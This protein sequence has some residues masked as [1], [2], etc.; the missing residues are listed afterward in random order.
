MKCL[1]FKIWLFFG[2][3]F[4]AGI[5]LFLCPYSSEFSRHYIKDDCY[6]H[7]AWIFDR[8]THNAT[9][10]DIAFI[11][12]SH[13]IHAFQEK[14]I[15]QIFENQYHVANFGYC[16]FGRNLEFVFIK[17]LLKYKSPRLLVIEV[18]EDEP[19][20]SHDIYPYLA[21][22]TDLLS[23]PTLVNRDYFA[24]VFTG[25]S[26]RMEQFK[27]NY[28]F[29][30]KYPAPDLNP[31]G[32]GESDRIA[33]AEELKLNE[34]VWSKRLK[35]RLNAQFEN[36]QL[37]Y[38]LAYLNK[39]LGLAKAKNIQVIYVYLPEYGSGLKEPLRM[40]EYE[41]TGEVLILPDSI[42]KNTG[43][44]MD[45][46]HFNNKGAKLVSIWMAQKLKIK[47]NEAGRCSVG[48]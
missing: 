16:R 33:P 11:G 2:L 43:N 39:S 6:N 12:S 35:N 40:K 42:L 30:E 17:E 25:L 37:K 9:P 29:F 27:S 34:Q 31:Y 45:A 4:L 10:T 24:D 18:H 3:A 23:T 7:G 5:I 41:K 26:A 20:N 15:E 1:L 21:G 38:P 46:T 8:I 22:T 32:Y 48:N 47:L 13:T 14:E 44:W 28:I 19:K 36:I